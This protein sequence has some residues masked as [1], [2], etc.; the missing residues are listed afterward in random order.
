MKNN[1]GPTKSY[2]TK[3]L[4]NLP[5]DFALS[6]ARQYINAALQEISRIESK[7]GKRAAADAQQNWKFELNKGLV[8]PHNAP[9]I[10]AGLDAL[11]EQEQEKMDAMRKKP[12]PPPKD[13]FLTG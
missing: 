5:N 3:A 8:N 7:R 12:E 6:S 10:V 11:I 13:K 4:R 9:G 2:L 1:T